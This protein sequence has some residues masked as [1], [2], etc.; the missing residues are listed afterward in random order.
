MEATTAT[1]I[2]PAPRMR[3][4]TKLMVLMPFAANLALGLSLHRLSLMWGDKAADSVWKIGYISC[5]LWSALVLRRYY[6]PDYFRR[7]GRDW[8]AVA[9]L[10]LG[11]IP[12]AVW[13]VVVMVLVFLDLLD[14]TG[15]VPGALG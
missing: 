15:L 8:G 5:V 13:A 3:P 14:K 11:A 2:P 7:P 10:V 6:R 4:L 9:C 12:A 1:P